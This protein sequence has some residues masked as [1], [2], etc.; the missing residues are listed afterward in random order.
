MKI[1]VTGSTGFIGS[2]L[3]S[4]FEDAIPITRKDFQSDLLVKKIAS[5]DAVINLAGMPIIRRWSESYR[6]DLVTSR[7][8]TTRQVV[9]AVNETGTAHLISVS[10]VGIYPDGKVCDEDC[11]E[12]ARDFL[13]DL[14]AMWEEEASHC[15]NR[16]TITRL[17]VVLGK[18]GG[19][20]S[21]MLVPF[22][23]GIGGPIG[24]GRMIM[25]WIA[26]HDLA[27]LFRFI[28]ESEL[29]GIVNAVSPI[30]VTNREFTRALASVLNRPA[31]IPVPM[32]VLRLL[33]GDAASVL[34][35]S[36]EVYPK[37]ALKAGFR[38]EYP[39]IRPALENILLKQKH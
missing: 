5:A 39:E 21:K 4:F 34:T 37:R 18:G 26:M 29:T 6:Y 19:A 2:Y 22:W 9:K 15:V 17:G 8:E 28:L 7:I 11:P 32:F 14:A 3:I 31:F 24:N 33:Y 25:S 35:A 36:K 12:R 16:L 38:F 10:A 13:G 23:L 30:P 27:R 1:A 20:L